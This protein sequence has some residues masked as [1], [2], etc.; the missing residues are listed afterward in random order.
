MLPAIAIIPQALFAATAAENPEIEY[1]ISMFKQAVTAFEHALVAPQTELQKRARLEETHYREEFELY[2]RRLLNLQKQFLADPYKVL[3]NADNSLKS[4]L[5]VLRMVGMVPPSEQQNFLEKFKKKIPAAV[6]F[7]VAMLFTLPLVRNTF[8]QTLAMGA[9][10]EGVPRYII[11]GILTPAEIY[12]NSKLT[13]PAVDVTLGLLFC[14]MPQL[15]LFKLYPLKTSI[16]AALGFISQSFS[17]AA[18]FSLFVAN[19][20]GP[21]KDVLK[22]VASAG[23]MLYHAYG[24]N[25]VAISAF[26]STIKDEFAKL[27]FAVEAALEKASWLT[28]EKF[29]D[30]IVKKP[31][32]MKTLGVNVFDENQAA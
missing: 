27:A 5:D 23:I 3:K 19:Y 12:R 10:T 14:S 31:E 24:V 28:Y 7:S 4:L 2:Q 16:I 18:I 22:W 29:V 20:D 1:G 9:W 30:N 6:G 17:H 25:K 26:Q 15:M 11:T 32:V 8:E 21:A 13:I